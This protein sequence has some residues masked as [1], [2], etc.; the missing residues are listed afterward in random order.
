MYGN[1]IRILCVLLEGGGLS[2]SIWY[3]KFNPHS[4]FIQVSCDSIAPLITT[5]VMLIII[6]N[7]FS[8]SYLNIYFQAI[9]TNYIVVSTIPVISGWH[10]SEEQLEEVAKYSEVLETG[11]DF[12]RE[13]FRAACENLI[14]FPERVEPGQCM[15]A[16]VYLKN[17][18]QAPP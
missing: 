13:D 1:H 4:I 9:S 8:I 18:F 6:S 11:S 15:D 16:F 3:Q 12:L 5:S 17:N 7:P 10:V 14:P 2:G